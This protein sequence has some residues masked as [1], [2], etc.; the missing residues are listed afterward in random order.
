MR[1][2]REKC[3]LALME[4]LENWVSSIKIQKLMFLL[5]E[6]QDERS[7]D[8]MPYKFGC[9]SMQLS[10]DLRKLLNE[11]YLIANEIDTHQYK[12]S[13]TDFGFEKK[14]N[15]TDTED[16]KRIIKRFGTWADKELIKYTYLQYP[17][18]AINSIMAKDILSP[19]ELKIINKHRLNK[20]ERCL[21]TIGYEGRSLEKY[22]VELLKN[23]VKVLCD[24]RK[25]AFSQKFGFSKA[26]LLKACEGTGISY[27]HLPNLGIIS[28]KRKNLETQD[29][30]DI[31]FKEYECTVLENSKAE[32]N[33]IFQLLQ[34]EKRVALT[35]YERDFHQCHRSRIAQKLMSIRQCNY[36][37][38]NI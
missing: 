10:R 17:F 11:G 22:I 4:N 5:S 23:G 25:N 12:I 30:Y 35:C 1:F 7:Y 6:R 20:E 9:Y 15:E 14:I 36:L 13:R 33:I 38:E 16:I 8:F 26:Q 32:L 34:N 18:F 3:L 29:D 31:L 24:V 19:I 21:F 28:E 37:L 2:Y 27:I